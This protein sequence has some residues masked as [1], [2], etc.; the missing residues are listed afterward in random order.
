LIV[1]VD[2]PEPPEMLVELKEL[3]GPVGDDVA[4]RV[5]APEN[6]LRAA[7]LMVV[8]PELPA[9]IEREVGLAVIVKSEVDEVIAKAVVCERSPLVPVTVT[10]NVPLALVRHDRVEVP[11]L[12]RLEDVRLHVIPVDGEADSESDTVP[13][14]LFRKFTVMVEVAD[15]PVATDAVVGLAAREKSSMV[16]VTVAVSALDPLAPVTVTA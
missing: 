6:P 4:D 2:E 15:A 8:E 16:M 13:V 9:W 7:M 11:V 14:K 3:V 12:V 10:V 5:T 1:S